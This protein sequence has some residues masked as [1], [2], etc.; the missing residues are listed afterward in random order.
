M[1]YATTSGD[2]VDPTRLAAE[3]ACA[4]PRDY[5]LHVFLGPSTNHSEHLH[6]IVRCRRRHGRP[7]IDD[8]LVICGGEPVTAVDL[9]ATINWFT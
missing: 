6:R 5:D 1:D 2:S 7:T 3:S 8:A 9:K 4:R